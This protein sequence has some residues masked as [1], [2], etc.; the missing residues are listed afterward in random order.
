MLIIFHILTKNFQKGVL[1]WRKAQDIKLV[2]SKG[3]R[4]CYT[5][6]SVTVFGRHFYTLKKTSIFIYI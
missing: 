2:V 4:F 3:C 1:E 6:Y 5:C